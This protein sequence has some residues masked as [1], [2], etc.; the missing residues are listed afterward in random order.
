MFEK[1][2]FDVIKKFVKNLLKANEILK[3]TDN[4]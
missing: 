4:K 1:I 2:Q 3:S